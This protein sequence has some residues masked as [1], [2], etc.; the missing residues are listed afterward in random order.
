[1]KKLIFTYI[2]FIIGLIAKA[3]DVKFTASAPD[4]VV[5]GEQFRLTYTVNTQKV[6]EF[7]APEMKGFNVLMGPTS[8]R[9]SST[10]IINGNMTSTS[11]ITYTYILEAV[12]EGTYRISGASIVAN[13]KE[14]ISNSLSI[15]VLPPD[16]TTGNGAGSTARSSDSSSSISGN[17]LFVVASANKTNVYEQ[18]AFLVTFKVYTTLNLTNFGYVKAPDF[19]G[20]HA[21]EVELPS[22]KSF[23]LDHYKG[24]NY[25]TLVWSQFVLFPQ[26]TGNLEIPSCEFEAIIAKAV[27]SADPFDAFFNGGNSYVQVKKKITSPKVAIHVNPLPGNKP[28]S[29]CGAV[30]D[31]SISSSINTKELKTNDAVT[32]K[33]IVSGTG[34]MKL[35]DTPDVNF[36]KDFEIYD[37]KSDNKFSLTSNGLSGNKVIEYLAIPRHAG[38]YTIPPVEFSYFDLKSKSY[39][40]LKTETYQLKVAKGE[41]NADQVIANFANKEDVKMLGQDIRFIKIGEV[42]YRP[43][44]D[45]FVGSL[46][47]YLCYLMPLCLFVLFVIIYRK[48]LIENAN[49]AKVKTKKANKVATKRM[50]QASKLLAENKKGEFYDEV[51]KALWGYVS[52]KLSIPVSQLSKDNIESELAR[53][54]ADEEVVKEFIDVLNQCEFVRYAPGDE[55]AAMDHIYKMA[56]EL[57]SKME[58]KIK[59]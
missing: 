20:F 30:G 34:N 53:Y 39:K 59:H 36:P 12:K 10:S 6:R 32:V 1:M 45:L 21:Q 57:I 2:L 49:I 5:S 41:G 13:G 15:R 29:F 19:K 40:T 54:G 4:A 28:A 46:W 17:E 33:L 27:Q 23:S 43:N 50:K 35:I 24:K 11:S 38:E 18:E 7:R 3:D 22:T 26:Q 14:T 42:N 47:Y 8:S 58:N 44:G 55:N 25:R 37:P 51:L 31:F 52:D 56:V 48:Q 16:Q 9:Q